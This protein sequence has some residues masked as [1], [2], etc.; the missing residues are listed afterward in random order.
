[1]CFIYTSITVL[2]TY[3]IIAKN[4][5]TTYRILSINA[6]LETKLKRDMN[7]NVAEITTH[8]L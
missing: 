2:N 8:L 4:L 5:T 6:F 7:T 3:H 1:M